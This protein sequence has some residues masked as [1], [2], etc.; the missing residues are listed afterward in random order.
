MP[1][2]SRRKESADQKQSLESSPGGSLVYRYSSPAKP[3]IGVP[4]T[5]YVSHAKERERIYDDLFGKCKDVLHELPPL[6]PHI[7]VYRYQPGH[8]CRDFWTLVTS[9]MS[10]VTMTL[11]ESMGKGC[12]RAELIFYCADPKEPYSHML[13]AMARFPH[14]NKTWLGA[15]H[16]IPNGNPPGP[17]FEDTP[18]LDCFLFM[19]SIVRPDNKLGIRLSIG[20]DPV[21]FLWVVPITS[22]EEDPKLKK[23]MNAIYDLL[24]MN[25]HPHVFKGNRKSYV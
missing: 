1:L 22:A 8:K 7:D 23:G 21:N 14:D 24:D 10:D 20:G 9:G 18:D 4:G 3:L 19:P 12:A 2:W 13:Q 11:P 6:V 25:R 15:G 17:L 16:T 5:D